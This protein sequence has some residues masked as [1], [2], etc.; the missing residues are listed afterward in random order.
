MSQN[1]ITD[2]E[3]VRVARHVTWVGFWCNAVLGAAKVVAGIIGHSGAVVADGVHSFSDFI[4]D[5]VILVMVG[6]SRKGAD[7]KYQYGHGKYETMATM[8]IALCLLVVGIGIFWE[9][10]HK[11]IETV[12]GQVLERP[13]YIALVM[14]VV[15]IAV[16]E[17]LYHYTRRAGE[18]INSA[19]VVAN[20]WH[21]RSD[22]F[23]SAATVIGVTGAIF[24]GERWRI[25]DPV[26][27]MI[28]A[29]FIVIVSVKLALPSI[30]ELLEEAL[31]EEMES[32]IKDAIRSTQGVYTF[33][34]LRSRRSGNTIIVDVDL[35]VAPDITVVEA[36]KI[37]SSAEKSIARRMGEASTI[38]TT[39]IEPYKGEE[40]LADGSCK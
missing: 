17:W 40:I 4:T 14:C 31:P 2:D 29:V 19:A 6:V 9:G 15:S 21:H 33:H 36:H 38:V 30:R 8:I 10:L 27:A 25:L 12:N 13:G 18:R 24:L 7:R 22:A 5:A 20:A 26:A 1:K 39:H 32:D 16:K 37:A 3:A 34:H 11:V 23:S 35:K 28:V